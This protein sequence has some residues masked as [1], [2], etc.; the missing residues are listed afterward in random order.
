MKKILFGSIFGSLVPVVVYAQVTSVTNVDSLITRV[1]YLVNSVIWMFVSLALLFIIWNVV[2]FIRNTDSE[3]RS[4]YRTAVMWGIV[5]LF[6]IISIWGLVNILALTF[7]VDNASGKADS[8]QKIEGLIMQ[9]PVPGGTTGG[10][11]GFNPPAQTITP[12]A[13]QPAGGTASPASGASA[14]PDPGTP[15]PVAPNSPF[16]PPPAD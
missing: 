13:T 3:K 14:T 15:A 7:N 10:T 12:P 2:Q 16:V 4:E 11:G 9:R 5:G 6:I 8:T 1:E